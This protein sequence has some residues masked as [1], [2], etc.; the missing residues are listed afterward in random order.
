VANNAKITLS[1][2]GVYVECM[3]RKE[4]LKQERDFSYVK[5]HL[6]NMVVIVKKSKRR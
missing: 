2:L 1:K 3:E 5:R 4:A 6:L